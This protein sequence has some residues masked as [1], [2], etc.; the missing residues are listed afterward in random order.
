MAKIAIYNDEAQRLYVHEGLSLDAIMG[1]LGNKVS[2]KTL[3]NWKKDG[4][5]EEKRKIARAAAQDLK[6]RLKRYALDR[7]NEAEANPSIK[8]FKLVMMALAAVEKFGEGSLLNDETATPEQKK[9][10]E[11]ITS[12]PEFKEIIRGI[13]GL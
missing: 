8:S 6:S 7:M 3:Y 12:S 9:T 10:I 11:Q 2:R 5:W 1:V 13:Y 4:D